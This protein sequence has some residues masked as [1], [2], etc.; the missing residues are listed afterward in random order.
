MLVAVGLDGDSCSEADG[1]DDSESEEITDGAAAVVFRRAVAF[2]V[3]ALEDGRVGL[4]EGGL[5]FGIGLEGGILLCLF[6]EG[7]GS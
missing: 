2:V 3:V 6:K 7:R 5:R 4:N 1:E